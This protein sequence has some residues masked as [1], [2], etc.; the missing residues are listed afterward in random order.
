MKVKQ[1]FAILLFCSMGLVA[2]S[3]SQHEPQLIAHACGQL[4][5]YNYTNS[6]EAMENALKNGYKFIEVDL[7]LTSDSIPV[8]CHYWP[9]FNEMT[10]YPE[11]GDSVPSFEDFSNRLIYNR[12]R[13]INCNDIVYYLEQYPDWTFVVD[14]LDDV[15]ILERYFGHYKDRLLVECFSEYAYKSLLLSGF[16]PMLACDTETLRSIFAYS[17]E[18]MINGEAPIDY[19]TWDFEG[20]YKMLQK[21]KCFMSFKVAGFTLDDGWLIYDYIADGVD[22]VYTNEV[23]PRKEE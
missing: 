14:K 2:R 23:L 9:D 20:N 1:V 7:L 6:V 22:F 18:S 12:Y 5:G 10:G 15:D 3:Q 16:R 8:G 13:P 11:M 17:I 21:Y 19:I 4:D